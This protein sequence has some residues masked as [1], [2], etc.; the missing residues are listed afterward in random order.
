MKLNHSLQYKIKANKHMKNNIIQKYHGV[1]ARK[2][3]DM[4]HKNGED[5]ALEGENMSSQ[6]W[7]SF[8]HGDRSN[9]DGIATTSEEA[10]MEVSYQYGTFHQLRHE[11]IDFHLHRRVGLMRIEIIILFFSTMIACSNIAR[12]SVL[13]RA[14]RRFVCLR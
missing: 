7:E 6:A 9:N 2:Q 3:R 10:S 4:P 5:G 8:D 11:S 14:C 1:V 13:S 12:R